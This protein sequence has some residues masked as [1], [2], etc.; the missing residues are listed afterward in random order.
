MS[1]IPENVKDQTDRMAKSAIVGYYS[2][3]KVYKIMLIFR[4]RDK[5]EYD[6]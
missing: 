1:G 5:N 2:R 4:E 3:Y 6:E